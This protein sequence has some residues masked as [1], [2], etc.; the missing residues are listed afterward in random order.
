[1]PQGIG[2]SRGGGAMTPQHKIEGGQCIIWPSPPPQF[3]RPKSQSENIDQKPSITISFEDE[4]TEN[5]RAFDAVLSFSI[6]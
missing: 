6:I 1:M 4:E 2:V 5:L 3:K